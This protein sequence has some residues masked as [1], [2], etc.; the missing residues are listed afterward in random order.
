M[1][2]MV[3]GMVYTTNMLII[4]YLIYRMPFFLFFLVVVFSDKFI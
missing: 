3:N 1:F 2:G 4:L